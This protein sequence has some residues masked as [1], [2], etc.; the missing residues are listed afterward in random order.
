MSLKDSSNV[1]TR[2]KSQKVYPSNPGSVYTESEQ[3]DRDVLQSGDARDNEVSDINEQIHHENT[4]SMVDHSPRM[5]QRNRDNTHDEGSSRLQSH[6][7][8]DMDL[9]MNQMKTLQETV[10]QMA[11]VAGEQRIH[12]G[13][14]RHRWFHGNGHESDIES[15]NETDTPRTTPEARGSYTK[16]PPF[17]GREAWNVWFNRFEEIATRQNWSNNRRLDEMLPRLQAQ[18]GDF[19]FGQ[20]P[21]DKRSNYKDLCHE[22]NNRFRTI[23]TSKSFKTQFSRRQQKS[24]EK[25][26]DYAAELKRLYDKAYP[27]RDYETRTEDLVRKFFDGVNDEKARFHVEYVKEPTNIDEAVF[28]IVNFQEMKPVFK[29][30]RNKEYRYNQVMRMQDKSDFSD[31]E[32]NPDDFES[33]IA[34]TGISNKNRLITKPAESDR[35]KTTQNENKYKNQNEEMQQ[36]QRDIQALKSELNKCPKEDRSHGYKSY[37]NPKFQSRDEGWRRSQTRNSGCYHCGEMSHFIRNCPHRNR[38]N[39]EHVNNIK[40]A[41]ESGDK[42]NPLNYNGPI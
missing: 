19:V 22:L 40:V 27:R 3:C 37:F 1:M 26:E 32:M 25:V 31:E 13:H 12:P 9:L 7:R 41:G 14:R 38:T 18:A 34:R 42:T 15:E 35:S 4:F 5:S 8:R 39:T 29:D 33:R 10:L 36:M 24:G 23:E 6:Q 17:T 28:E 11:S 16:L 21:Q 30:N 20:L 2:S